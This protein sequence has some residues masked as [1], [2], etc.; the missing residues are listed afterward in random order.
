MAI[1][2]AVA[3][4]A[5]PTLGAGAGVSPWSGP[6]G[7]AA[8]PVQ[9]LGHGAGEGSAVRSSATSAA[10]PASLAGLPREITFPP[11]DGVGGGA[12]AGVNPATGTHRGEPGTA[13]L[14]RSATAAP[15]SPGPAHQGFAGAPAA[16]PG[17]W[18]VMTLHHPSAPSWPAPQPAAPAPAPIL[19]RIVAAPAPAAAPSQPVVQASRAGIPLGVTATPVVQRVDGSA[20]EPGGAPQAHT[21]TE[22]DELARAIFGRIRTHLRSEVI[23]EREAK[24][25]SFDSF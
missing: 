25:L 15:P 10:G 16:G 13:S 2:A 22:L 18:P 7:E 1:G 20:P 6:F 21:E 17:S 4:D 19:Q 3:T 9:R 14:Q 8:V 11:R 12:P 24:G 23:H 5:T